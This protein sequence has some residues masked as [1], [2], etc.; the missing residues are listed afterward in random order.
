M[1]TSTITVTEEMVEVFGK[2][3]EGVI[4]W[5]PYTVATMLLLLWPHLCDTYFHEHHRKA[6]STG[7]RQGIVAV[8]RERCRTNPI[9][10]DSHHSARRSLAQWHVQ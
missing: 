10:L 5:R 4:T 2:G 1:N 6:E 7:R 9:G 8:S 3:D